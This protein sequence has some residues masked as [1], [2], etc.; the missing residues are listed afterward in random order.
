MREMAGE[1]VPNIPFVQSIERK[2]EVIEICVHRV[3]WPHH[4]ETITN[5]V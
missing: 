1:Q 5:G 4:V 2:I 3:L